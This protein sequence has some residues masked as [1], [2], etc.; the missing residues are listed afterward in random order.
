MFFE[1]T[2]DPKVRAAIAKA[3]AERAKAFTTSAR[4]VFK[5]N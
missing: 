1:S 2:H 5:K 3:H 4:R